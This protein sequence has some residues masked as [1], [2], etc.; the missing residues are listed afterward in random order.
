[1]TKQVSVKRG[2]PGAQR[3]AP[4]TAENTG[5][6]RLPDEAL[7]PVWVGMLRAHHLVVDRLDAVLQAKHHLPL[8]SYEALLHLSFQPEQRMR[9]SA[10]AASVVL[11][12]SGISR[13]TDRLEKAGLVRREPSP[14]DGR[15]AYAA[16]TED[17][18]A[19]L[20]EAEA[21]HLA[22][23]R[24]YFLDSLTLEEGATL[25][26]VWERLLSRKTPGTECET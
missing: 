9:L 5:V 17:G 8:S 13:L 12:Q 11:T 3:E 19:L 21:T 22:A 4:D 6:A 23:V 15:G 24:A 25:A 1:L 20:H 16:L 26:R 18:R 2:K 10:L 14:G 7:V